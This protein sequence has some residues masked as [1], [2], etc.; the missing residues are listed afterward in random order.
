M[1]EVS[2]NYL[3]PTPEALALG[4]HGAPIQQERLA[5][6]IVHAA[7]V[8]RTSWTDGWVG[9][10]QN[11]PEGDPP[12]PEDF[13]THHHVR[14]ESRANP[15]VCPACAASPG[16][17][18][19]RVCGG[20]GA[21]WNGQRCSCRGGLVTC[22]TCAGEGTTYTSLLRYYTDTPALMREAY[23]PS[24]VSYV[25]ALFR[26][27][28]AMEQDIA[29][30]RDMPEVLRC[31]DLS[32]KMGGSAYRGGERRVKPDFQGYDFGDAIE[33]AITGLKAFWGG[34]TVL[35]YDIRA[36]AWPFLWLRY[37]DRDI[38]I[39]RTREGQ[40]RSFGDGA[41]GALT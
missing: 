29:F 7:V 30:Q 17:R 21:L 20:S 25:P 31:H 2:E 27:E 3:P 39:Y 11:V 15:R 24:H 6:L 10:L 23:I 4:G 12:P 18:P 22:P 38:A 40:V 33:K 13:E 5:M 19:C 26:L 35:K 8:R 41:A 37:P 1:Y 9:P 16:S 36:Y 14:L 32:G 34:T 28:S